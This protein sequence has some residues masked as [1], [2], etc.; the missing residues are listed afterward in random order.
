[1]TLMMTVKT[2][3]VSPGKKRRNRN[4]MSSTLRKLKKRK[5]NQREA[6]NDFLTPC[7][8]LVLTAKVFEVKRHPFPSSRLREDIKDKILSNQILH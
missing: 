2:K 5:L 4:K 1:M 6:G 3:N 8:A 7:L